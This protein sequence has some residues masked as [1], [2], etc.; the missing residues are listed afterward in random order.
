MRAEASARAGATLRLV[1]LRRR[2]PTWLN[3][4][5]DRLLR[6]AAEI[7]TQKGNLMKRIL[8]AALF[9]LPVVACADR[10][11]GTAGNPPSTATQRAYDS[12]TGSPPT[13]ADGRG[14]NPSGTAATRALDQ[15]AGTNTSGA[16]PS[17]R[18]GTAANPPGTAAE[19]AYDRATGSNTSGAYP[20]N[21][22]GVPQR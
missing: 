10:T 8:V 5:D 13:S 17:Q 11:D 15:A 22:G 7:R 9:A 19:R 4:T 21:S 1:A 6:R 12:A 2:R 18:D 3:V 14:N 20:A 16:Y